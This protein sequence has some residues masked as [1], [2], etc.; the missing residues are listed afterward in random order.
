MFVS[1]ADKN[2]YVDPNN[3]IQHFEKVRIVP[4]ESGDNSMADIVKK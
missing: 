3:A 1:A 2:L 4:T